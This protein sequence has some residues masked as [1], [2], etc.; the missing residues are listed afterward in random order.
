MGEV[1]KLPVDLLHIISPEKIS[2]R[3]S[4]PNVH[5]Q[6]HQLHR[7]IQQFCFYEK[8]EMLKT[9][10]P[11]EGSCLVKHSSVYYRGLVLPS[12]S[13]AP[14]RKIFRRL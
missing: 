6:F 4:H 12:S 8:K 1:L 11:T 3:I 5:L 14:V 9:I 13:A 2:V 10:D 7:D